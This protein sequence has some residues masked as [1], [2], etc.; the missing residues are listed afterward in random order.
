[1]G[2]RLYFSDGRVQHAGDAIGPGGCANH[3]YGVI[4]A[5]DPGYMNRAVLPQELSAVTAACLLTYRALYRELGGLDEQNLAVAFNDVDFCLRVREA[6]YRVVYTPYAELYHYESVSRGKDDAPEK[7][8]RAKRE[9]NYMRK[10]WADVIERDPFYN[11]NL[12][13]AKPDFTL[14]KYPR[15]D[16]PW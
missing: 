8:A 11:P 14:G 5:D 15:I 3:L 16:W 6:G 4:E 13:Y 9:V 12:N 1:V 10:R 2:A 7:K